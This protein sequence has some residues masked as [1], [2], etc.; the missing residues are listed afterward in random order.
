MKVH[1]DMLI[2]DILA[3]DPQM[4]TI[5]MQRGMHCIS[6]IAATG[7]TLRE[8]GFVHGMNEEMME[9]LVA[10]LNDYLAAGNAEA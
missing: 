5:L 6:C 2:S 4:A 9:D 10:Q 8:A 3:V 1:A 7:E